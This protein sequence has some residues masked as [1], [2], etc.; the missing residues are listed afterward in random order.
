MRY[1]LMAAL[2]HSLLYSLLIISIDRYKVYIGI[3][4]DLRFAS[5]CVGTGTF[6]SAR[7]ASGL[8][9]Q[10]V[11]CTVWLRVCANSN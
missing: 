10:R 8:S 4:F 3:R 6:V 11:G 7:L 5:W 2:P 1:P 9:A